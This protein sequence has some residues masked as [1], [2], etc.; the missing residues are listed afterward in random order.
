MKLGSIKGAMQGVTTMDLVG[1]VAGLA[2]S[3]LIPPMIIKPAAGA[4]LTSTQKWMRVG[5]AAAAAVALGY[6][7]KYIAKGASRGVIIGGLSGTA[8]QLIFNLTNY[9]ISGVRQLSAPVGR[10]V[11]Y[12]G[13]ISR[14]YEPEF[15]NVGT[16]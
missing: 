8:S 7:S 6:A 12:G 1:A 11:P 9:K 16:V 4:A 15:K 10:V 13:P 5:V 14:T 3:T 2:A